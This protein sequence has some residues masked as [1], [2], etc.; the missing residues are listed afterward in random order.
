MKGVF[1]KE[2][3]V[4]PS[5]CNINAQMKLSGLLD[6]FMDDAMLHAEEI[7]VGISKFWPK[8]MF[9]V[10]SKT[11]IVF[12]RNVNMAEEVTVRTWPERPGMLKCIRDYEMTKG[13]ETVAYGKTEWVIIDLDTKKILKAEG[14][15]PTE[16]E[17]EEKIVDD[18]PFL[19]IKNDF[20]DEVFGTY[21]VRSVDL[22]YGRHMNNVAYVRA[23]E[24]L[25][26]SDEWQ[27]RN[28]NGIEIQ[29][30]CSC[31]EKDVLSFYKKEEAGG[32]LIKASNDKGEN[33][34]MAKLLNE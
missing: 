5:S 30:K 29:Y 21:T 4:L 19:R 1:E 23:I 27:E 7:G 24:G 32:T 20:D 33:V 31:Y 17:Y 28:Y 25:F 22:D 11:R 13:E 2:T 34:M 3:V 14:A 8:R 16:L 10:A 15:Y 6:I 18:E 9:W 12:K 26:S